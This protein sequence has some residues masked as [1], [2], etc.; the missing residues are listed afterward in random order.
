M[1]IV[2]A[3]ATTIVAAVATTDPTTD[4]PRF[5]SCQ[6]DRVLERF[7]SQ[8]VWRAR[9]LYLRHLSAADS[10]P[11]V[12]LTILRPDSGARTR[13][14]LRT[15]AGPAVTAP[16]HA[17]CPPVWTDRRGVVSAAHVSRFRVGGWSWGGFGGPCFASSCGRMVM[18]RLRQHTFMSPCARIVVAPP[19]GSTEAV[20]VCA[21]RRIHDGRSS[22]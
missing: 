16:A 19:A 2:A 10:T 8:G 14:C 9:E 22:R 12:R 3:V 6:R 21:N 5:R 13:G 17:S 18:G 11:E 4:T 20:N 7:R 1:T 15:F